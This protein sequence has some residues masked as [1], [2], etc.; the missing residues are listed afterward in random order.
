MT[1]S[2]TNLVRF[3]P[4]DTARFE[5]PAKERIATGKALRKK[6][7]RASHAEFAA[8]ARRDLIQ[9]LKMSDQGRLDEL[10]PIRYGRMKQSPFAFFRG[11]A[12]LMASDL[13]ITPATGIR[14]QACGD[15]HAA[16]F[17]GFASPER[18]LLFGI[19]DFDE[20]LPAPWEWD[21][22]RLAASTVLVSRE[23][24]L[25]ATQSDDVTISM[26]ESYR[27]HMRRYSKM[28][29]LD[30]WY[31]RIRAEVLIEKAKSQTAKLRWKHIENRARLQTSEHVFP[32]MA[33]LKN[34]QVRLVDHLPLVYH[35]RS[36]ELIR[37]H[38]TDMFHRYKATLSA[39][40]RVI[41]DRY[42]IVDV[43]R[44]VV[45]VGSVG[46]RCAVILLMAGKHDPLL[47][48]V[49][50][51]LPS[52]LEPFTGKSRYENHGERVVTGER[53]LR[54]AS[55]VFLGWTRD[56]NGRDYYFR[57]LRDM[58]MKI[59]LENLTKADW[60]EYVQVCGWSLARAHARSGDAAMISGYLGKSSAFDW[61]IAKF[62]AKYADQVEG[63]YA[64]LLKAI[65]EQH[66]PAATHVA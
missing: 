4:T 38:V 48:Q 12:A 30:L 15:C 52:V 22:K 50:Q 19:N 29:A 32:E 16:N 63:D 40:R 28:H 43:A 64:I 6:V 56:S 24:G 66:L 39:D 9:V 23:L 35:S 54:S 27:Q 51:A 65:R 57:Q 34:G 21:V 55:D 61:A 53:M 7:P 1:Q 26:V 41:F 17:G 11:C 8:A 5:R 36:S 37:Q 20:T 18:Q 14:V 59:D 3:R 13:A 10:L 45:G 44:K 49:K 47:L 2:S 58:K 31:S 46:T 60:I 62:A 42:R 33:C 25:A